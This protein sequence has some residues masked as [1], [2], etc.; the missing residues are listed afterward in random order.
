[1][2][3]GF[4]VH[5]CRGKVP[6]LDAWQER[7]IT[8]DQIPEFFKNGENVGGIMG[9]A[10]GGR[11]DVDCD[12]PEAAIVAPRLLR[13]TP[14]RFGRPSNRSSHL[15][16]ISPGAKSLKLTDPT[17]KEGEARASIIE[18]R[19]DRHNT[20]L[21]GSIHPSG[22][23]VSWESEGPPT[24]IEA[25]ELERGI[26]RV[27]VMVLLA[28]HYP[29]EGARH[30]FVMAL[31]GTL[32]RSDWE[33]EEAEHF[34]GLLAE[35]CRDDERGD[36]EEAVATT[37]DR[38]AKGES[39]TGFK[40]LAEMLPESVGKAIRTWLDVPRGAYIRTDIGNQERFVDEHQEDVR[41]VPGLGFMVWTGTHWQRDETDT[42]TQRAVA[43]M[44]GQ[45]QEA[46]SNTGAVDRKE[47][48]AF[49]LKSEQTSSIRA[50]LSLAKSNA[51]VVVPIAALDPDPWLLNVE[52][53]TIDLKNGTIREHRREDLLTHCL[54]VAYAPAAQ[55]SL[56]EKFLERVF[57]AMVRGVEDRVESIALREYI[58]RAFGYCLTGSTG[59]HV[60]FFMHGGGRNGKGVF[61]RVQERLLG[62]LA[63]S[64]PFESLLESKHGDKMGND[65]ARLRG[66]R[67]A[68]ASEAGPTRAFAEA[69]IKQLTGGDTITARFMYEDFFEFRPAFKI[70]LAANHRP[71]V[72]ETTEAF[73]SR[74][75]LIPFNITIPPEERVKDYGDVLADAELPGILNWA[76]AGCLAW[77]R[78]GLQ[79]PAAV[80][81]A[82]VDYRDGQDVIGRFIADKCLVGG[83]YH[84]TSAELYSAFKAWAETNGEYVLSQ[85]AFGETLRDRPERFEPKKIHQ[86]RAWIGITVKE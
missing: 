29:P 12:C 86:V 11:V 8:V 9:E 40:T 5:P 57:V 1:M 36:R 31:S 74:I 30:K 44:R 78:D 77:Q 83:G 71:R 68:L 65:I 14:A 24:V 82:T 41:Y 2:D 50:L 27:A 38:I 81:L 10:S 60:L 64:L 19:A 15:I 56:W 3:E 45:T 47:L 18:L 20:V 73:W 7:R 84:A 67:V 4:A 76:L 33:T 58:R 32:L 26:K 43:T 79:P 80:T 25:E 48:L 61:M 16:Y 37:A 51:K 22:E 72:R 42:V 34:V 53:G 55:A 23:L 66:R 6:I 59:E 52:N 75:K 63:G 46:L 17:V 28:R 35:V 62:A 49:V 54:P 85:T 69:K 39:A 70:W 21:P 13:S